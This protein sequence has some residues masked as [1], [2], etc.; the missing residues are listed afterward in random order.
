[1]NRLGVECDDYLMWAAH[2][3]LPCWVIRSE[4]SKV[5]HAFATEHLETFR[6][7]TM[8]SVLP[9]FDYG[10]EYINDFFAYFTWGHELD[11]TEEVDYKI[12]LLLQEIHCKRGQ[13]ALEATAKLI[14]LLDENGIELAGSHSET[15][16]ED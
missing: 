6:L 1:M 2:P 15:R 14:I 3:V 5:D 16:K 11:T 4:A 10:W 8:L 7:D 12:F 13:E 9:D